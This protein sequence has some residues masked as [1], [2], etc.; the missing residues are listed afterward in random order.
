VLSLLAAVAFGSVQ[1]VDYTADLD[2]FL[3][4]VKTYGAFVQEDH[5]DFAKLDQA[6]RPKFAAINTSAEFLPLME[7]LVAELHDFHASL[8]TN[9]DSSPRLVPSGTDIFAVWK[10]GKAVIDQVRPGSVAAGAGVVAGDEV[11]EINGR[12]AKEACQSWL[13]VLPA[14]RRGWEWALN[15]AL[16]GRWNVPRSLKLSRSG[17]LQS[18]TFATAKSPQAKGPLTVLRPEP[19][20]VLLRP[21]DS[22]GQER[23]IADL[24][25]LVPHLRRAR[26]VILDLR[27]TPSG[28]TTSVARGIMGLFIGARMPYQ[29]HLVREISTDTVR[30]WVEYATPRLAKPVRT[31]L[32]V[33]VSRWTG[34]MG[35]GIAI[36]FDA[37]KRAT[38][39]GTAMAG[40]R[41]AVD[42]SELPISKLRVFFPTERLFHINGTPRHEWLPKVLVKPGQGDPWLRAALMQLKM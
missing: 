27:S 31:P 35:E 16:A 8:N 38:V 30:D 21:E 15:S 22:L 42:S 36:G 40:L 9:N 5:V 34:S 19:G 29:R 20:V 23:S 14:G 13:G 33:L 28:G 6:Y 39:V 37:M 18:L 12:S 11:L 17:T 10:N 26:G 32:V 41:G 25:R 4:D 7:A 24:D 2:Q 3:S 1:R